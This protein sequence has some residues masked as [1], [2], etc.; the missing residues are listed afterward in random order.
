M[1]P[2][3]LGFFE[4]IEDFFPLYLRVLG[5]GAR[6]CRGQQFASAS[7]LWRAPA[8][9]PGAGSACSLEN[10]GVPSALLSFYVTPARCLVPHWA[11]A[12]PPPPVIVHTE[13]GDPESG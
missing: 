11:G 10:G 8:A 12:G 9:A 5:K 1:S 2:K 4:I 6:R 3:A 13:A 7:K